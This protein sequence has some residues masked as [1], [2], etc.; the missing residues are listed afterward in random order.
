MEH[1]VCSTVIVLSREHMSPYIYCLQAGVLIW[2]YGL[3]FFKL[4]FLSHR[5]YF[6]LFIY[7]FTQ[8]HKMQIRQSLT[9]DSV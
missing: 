1:I 8:I 5:I 2:G 3:R 7:Y 9:S 6:I 4:Y